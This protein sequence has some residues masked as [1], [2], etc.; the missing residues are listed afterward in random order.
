MFGAVWAQAELRKVLATMGARVAEVEVDRAGQ[1]FDA[2]GLLVD[3][4][5]RG[6]LREALAILTTAA[7]PVSAAA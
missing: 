3:D 6:E 1:R 7:F 4:V 5:V 2:A